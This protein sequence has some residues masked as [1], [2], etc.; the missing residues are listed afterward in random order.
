VRPHGQQLSAA[1]ID[2]RGTLGDHD[3]EAGIQQVIAYVEAHGGSRFEELPAVGEWEA[4]VSNRVGFRRFDPQSTAWN[5]YVLPNAFRTELA[6][7]FNPK[8]VTAAMVKRGLILPGKDK[9]SQVLRMGRHGAMRVYVLKPGIIN[10]PEPERPTVRD[11]MAREMN[12]LPA[13]GDGA[14]KREPGSQIFH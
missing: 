6:K 14:G 5:Y 7:G 8:D 12:E 11:W 9:N 10:V 4:T 1:W 13:C 2:Q 3:I